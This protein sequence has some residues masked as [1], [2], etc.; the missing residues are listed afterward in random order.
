[1]LLRRAL[2]EEISVGANYRF[3]SDNWGLGSNTAGLQ[4][5]WLAAEKTTLTLRYRF[6][7][8]GSV[9]FYQR[10]YS[11]L[12]APSAFTTRDREQSP[13]H[14]HRIGVDWQQKAPIG[15]K[16]TVLLLNIGVGGDFYSYDKFVGLTQTKALELTL[17]VTLEK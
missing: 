11:T 7:T 6:Y 8:Q 10:I 1:V 2:T 16:S 3:Y 17:S 14:D 5:G 15:D 13:M 12:P 4:L 9:R